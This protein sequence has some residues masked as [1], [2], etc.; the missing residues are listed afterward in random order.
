VYLLCRMPALAPRRAAVVVLVVLGAYLLLAETRPPLLRAAVMA[1]CLCLATIFQRRVTSLNALAAAAVVLLAADPMQLFQPG[2]QLS[3]GIVAGILLL[4]SPVRFFL[5]GRWLSRRGLMVFRGEQRLARWVR[6]SLAEVAMQAVS[7]C[8]AAWV[9]AVPLVAY[10]FGYFSPYAPVLSVLLFP[11]VVAVLV[12]GY[13]S[14]ALAWAAP[15]L[16]YAIGRLAAAAA[17]LL[18][19]AVE[20]IGHL[21]GVGIELRPVGL[22]WVTAFYGALLLVVFHRRLRFGR[23]AAMAGVLA[24]AGVTALTQRTAPPPARAELNVL[25]V[26]NGQCTLLRT[27]SGTTCLFDIGTLGGF[28]A[29]ER[30]LAPFLR[31]RR[32]PAPR[33]VFVSHA[34]VDHYGGVSALARQGGLKR[35]Y[36]NDYFGRGPE[37]AEGPRQMLDLLAW[38]GVEV[39]RLRAP[40]RVKLDER[41]H[42][43]VK[44]D[45]RTHVEV[46]WP[47]PDAPD[48][49]KPNDTSLVLRVVCDGRSVLLPGDI[50]DAA[51]PQV[52]PGKADVLVLPHH[53]G[54]AGTLPDFV[55]AVNPRIVIASSRGSPG[56]PVA[57]SEQARAFYS[58]LAANRRLVTTGRN[59]WIQVRFGRG[60]VGLTTMR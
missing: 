13:V 59:G 51:Q 18:G 3:F 12:P 4:H 49:L 47:P 55:G 24:L 16:A 48:G 34:N 50:E 44:L 33:V 30:T 8:L 21:P 57:A 46:F 9:V 7:M 43:E 42:V 27:P 60:P 6:F 25:A 28:D 58:Q 40:M 41:T 2:F 15:N 10:H 31:A 5:F 23:P 20:A 36:V 35:V 17:G 53:G 32:L 1:A 14:V 26:G 29:Y 37:R 39:V 45:K 52:R 54:W 56:P 22:V 19:K 38:H 11:L